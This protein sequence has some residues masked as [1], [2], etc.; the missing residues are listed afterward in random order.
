MHTESELKPVTGH[1]NRHDKLG[2]NL[3]IQPGI[4]IF[5]E[6]GGKSKTQKISRQ[7]EI[8]RIVEQASL[9]VLGLSIK[10]ISVVKVRDV[11]E[12][13]DINA[14]FLSRKFKRHYHCNLCEF[15]QGEKIRRA[16]MI[17]QREKEIS[18]N[19]LS[20]KL[21]FSSTEYF[22]RVFKKNVGITPHK[23]RKYGNMN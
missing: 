1:R 11:A 3:N 6:T 12:H 5:L 9:Y 10:E 20:R 18:I 15:I 14:S 17:L 19:R 22:I 13:F 2:L 21:G 7:E 8:K 23:Y 4:S 16:I